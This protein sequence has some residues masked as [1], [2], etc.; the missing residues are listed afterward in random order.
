MDEFR[1]PDILKPRDD[2]PVPEMARLFDLYEERFGKK[3]ATAGLYF[4]DE[5]YCRIV[6]K[7]LK[8][9]KTFAEVT[10]IP[11]EVGEDEEI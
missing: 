7:C 5:E 6:K 2:V 11:D 8:R 1:I 3:I 4:S 9:N 10:G